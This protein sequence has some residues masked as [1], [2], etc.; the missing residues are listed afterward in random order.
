MLLTY[1][2]GDFLDVET[3]QII[4]FGRLGAGTGQLGLEPLRVII[5]DPAQCKLPDN[6]TRQATSVLDPV[7]LEILQGSTR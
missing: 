2:A 5:G 1:S 7:I 4:H 3:V 6:G